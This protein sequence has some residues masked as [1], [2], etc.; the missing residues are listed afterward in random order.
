MIIIPGWISNVEAI[1]TIPQLAAWIRYL[2]TICRILIFDKRGTGLSDRVNERE[3]PDIGQRAD[4]LLAVMDAT[5][6]QRAVLL[7]LSEGG[8][9][10][11]HFAATCPHRVI[12]LILIGTFARWVKSADYPYGLTRE[13]HQK[14]MDYLFAHWGEPIGLHLMA[15]SVKD[16]PVAQDHWSSYLRNSASPTTARAFY[17][18][19]IAIDV[20]PL[21]PALDAP[22]LIIHRRGDRLLE[23]GHSQYL[24]DHVRG[25]TLLLTPGNDHL[26][27]F[28]VNQ[29]ELHAIQMHVLGGTK[30]ASTAK[31]RLGVDDIASLYEAKTYLENHFDE[32]ISLPQLAKRL[33]MNE[34]K[35]KSGFKSLF[36][37]PVIEFLT[38][39]RLKHA[40]E[41]L[42][43][44]DDAVDKIARRVGYRH[45]SNFS[46]AF[47]RCYGVT[48]MQ[49]RKKYSHIA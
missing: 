3:L 28:G 1:D 42:S 34:F 37:S 18:M 35:L 20:R 8:P 44:T 36:D 33:G 38:T 5:Q 14:T 26:P 12:S 15:P 23:A 9:L 27:W 29:E 39:V 10:A 11:I 7:G 43:G 32:A 25:S 13:Q 48:P 41:M 21:L 30:P 17:E 49:Y 16:D 45:S 40:C 22:T 19:N 47:K 6:V 2:S 24:H 31:R 4:D 46:I